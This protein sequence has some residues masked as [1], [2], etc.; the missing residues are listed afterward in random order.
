MKILMMYESPEEKKAV[1]LQGRGQKVERRG[2]KPYGSSQIKS[3]IEATNLP[4]LAAG[5]EIHC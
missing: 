3:C 1:P 5:T 4:F 2:T